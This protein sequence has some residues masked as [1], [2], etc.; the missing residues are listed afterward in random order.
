MWT[1]GQVLGTQLDESARKA[2][3]I[4]FNTVAETMKLGALDAEKQ[5]ESS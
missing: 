3:L 4:L 1:L 5:S 2:W